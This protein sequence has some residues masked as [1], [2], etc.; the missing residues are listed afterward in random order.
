MRALWSGKWLSAE[1][2]YLAPACACIRYLD[3]GGKENVANADIPQRIRRV[4]GEAADGVKT[5][6]PKRANKRKPAVRAGSAAISGLFA[7][8]IVREDGPPAAKRIKVERV[9][10]PK[11]TGLLTLLAAEGAGAVSSTTTDVTAN[12]ARVRALMVRLRLREVDVASAIG[13]SAGALSHWLGGR[14]TTTPSTLRAGAAAMR[15]FE[16]NKGR[17]TS[18]APAPATLPPTTQRMPSG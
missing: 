16:E 2:L 3:D 7:P 11:T 14:H 12:A 6:A 1:V 10:G 18:A 9:R 13:V 4:A 15:W 5:E 8:G 17:P